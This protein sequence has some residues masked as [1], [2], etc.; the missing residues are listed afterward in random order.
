MGKLSLWYDDD[1]NELKPGDWVT[2]NG[3]IRT[4][5]DENADGD[6]FLKAVNSDLI[7]DSLEKV[8]EAPDSPDE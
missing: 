5:V 1:G 8:S 4:T 7:I 6:R 3:D 2:V